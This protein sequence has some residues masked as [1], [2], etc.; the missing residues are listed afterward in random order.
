[1]QLMGNYNKDIPTAVCVKETQETKADYDPFVRKYHV[2]MKDSTDRLTYDKKKYE[3]LVDQY[4][5]QLQQASD[6]VF[7]ACQHDG[8]VLVYCKSG[9]NRSVSVILTLGIRLGYPVDDL[10]K[11]IKGRI[12]SERNKSSLHNEVMLEAVRTFETDECALEKIADQYLKVRSSKRKNKEWGK[13]NSQ[14]SNL[15]AVRQ[16]LLDLDYLRSC[17]TIATYSQ[18][19]RM[20]HTKT[21]SEADEWCVPVVWMKKLLVEPR[22][23]VVGKGNSQIVFAVGEDAVLEGIP[24]KN[25]DNLLVRKEG[26]V[27]GVYLFFKSYSLTAVDK[28]TIEDST[29]A[30][31]CPASFAELPERCVILACRERHALICTCVSSNHIRVRK[32][33]RK[34]KSHKSQ[35]VE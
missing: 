27:D 9:M 8:D 35:K 24:T 30:L 7:H 22:P 17:D 33:R 16:K 19:W 14:D 15:Q 6:A 2:P 29:Y 28:S 26:D 5:D 34:N 23:Q 3:S 12:V 18:V 21:V 31:H 1:M 10:M 25:K 32:R 4:T 20:L 13:V 11:K